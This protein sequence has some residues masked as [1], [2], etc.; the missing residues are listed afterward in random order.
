MIASKNKLKKVL[1]AYKSVSIKKPQLKNTNHMSEYT[2]P[3]KEETKAANDLRL[4]IK[5]IC[6][7]LNENFIEIS[8][9][10]KN[11]DYMALIYHNKA[12]VNAPLDSDQE[13]LNLVNEIE[14]ASLPILKQISAEIKKHLGNNDKF[15]VVIDAN[16]S[17]LYS[18]K[19][20]KPFSV[21]KAIEV[22]LSSYEDRHKDDG[23]DMFEKIISD[24]L[25]H[26]GK[27]SLFGKY[28]YDKLDQIANGC[29]CFNCQ[30]VK[31]KATSKPANDKPTGY[32]FRN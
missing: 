18:T 3:S 24:A 31:D 30:S 15:V 28:L 22:H 19:S 6:T 16:S 10:G 7:A 32:H 2:Q 25:K 9:A 4:A 1:T 5:D 23:D 13:T 11:H 26:F 29:N 17:G 20:G 14:L 8:K 12:V 21:E 27:D